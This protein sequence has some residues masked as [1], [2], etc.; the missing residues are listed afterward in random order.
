MV[1][2]YHDDD[3]AG[4]EA[5]VELVLENLPVAAG[6]ARLSRFQIDQ[7]HSNAYAAWQRMGSPGAPDEHQYAQLQQAGQLAMLNEAPV[8]VPLTN[9]TV[10]MTIQLRRQA[11]ALLCFDLKASGN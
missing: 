5:R 9:G 6:E 11:V 1:W 4:P 2:H 3:V 7:E 8:T 10:A